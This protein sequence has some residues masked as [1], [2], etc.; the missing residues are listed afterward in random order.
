MRRIVK[1]IKKYYDKGIYSAEDVAEFVE[2]GLILPSEYT[3]I[4]GEPYIHIE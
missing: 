4:T 3:E 2:A 1:T